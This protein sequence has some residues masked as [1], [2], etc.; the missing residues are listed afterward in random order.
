MHGETPRTRRE[1]KERRGWGRVKENKRK[2]EG[3]GKGRG[4]PVNRHGYIKVTS[5]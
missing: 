5:R 1:R 2:R 4:I 3:V